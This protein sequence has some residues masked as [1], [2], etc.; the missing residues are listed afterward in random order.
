MERRRQGLRRSSSESSA[1]PKKKRVGRRG[2][3]PGLSRDSAQRT[4]GK[5]WSLAGRHSSTAPT[6]LAM[7]Y[8]LFLMVLY[9]NPRLRPLRSTRIRHDPQTPSRKRLGRRRFAYDFLPVLALVPG[10]LSRDS[11]VAT[12]GRGLERPR[13]GGPLWPGTRAS[14]RAGRPQ[15]GSGDGG[16]NASNKSR[17][18]DRL[19]GSLLSAGPAQTG[20]LISRLTQRHS[21]VWPASAGHAL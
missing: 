2:G 16:V 14:A 1:L 13:K 7:I 4:A 21:V 8:R 3:P 11:P 18:R 15:T 20:S 17:R 9:P 10:F 19:A 12:L 5:R 6:C